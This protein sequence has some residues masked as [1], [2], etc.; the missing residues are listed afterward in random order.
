MLF[1]QISPKRVRHIL[2][3]LKKLGREANKVFGGLLI[4]SVISVEAQVDLK[5]FSLL[6][7]R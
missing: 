3:V 7:R 2:Y 1:G 6:Q 4:L 5:N